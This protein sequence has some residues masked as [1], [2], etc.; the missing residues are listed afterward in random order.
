[1]IPIIAC[2]HP[3]ARQEV[4][5][6]KTATCTVAGYTGDTYCNDCGVK[7]YTGTTITAL[8]HSYSSKVTKHPTTI[9]EGIMTYTCS[10]CS[11]SY[12]RSIDKL[13]SDESGNAKKPYIKG[14]NGNEGW[15][16]IKNQTGKEED[17]DKITVEMNGTTI[18]PSD[19]VE[20]IRGKDVTLVLDMGDG[21]SWAIHGKDVTGTNLSDIDLKVS[22]GT[23]AIPVDV[24]N[25][26]TG[27]KYSMQ[28]SLAYEGE[29]GFK[30]TLSINM[31]KKNAGRY[32]SLFYYNEAMG[33]LEFMNTSL[34][35]AD[36]NVA[37]SFTH[38]S[39]YTI[40][41]EE[42]TVTGSSIDGSNTDT[43]KKQ[44]TKDNKNVSPATGNNNPIWNYIW[45]V[46]IGGMIMMIGLGTVIVK[47]KKEIEE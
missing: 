31:D 33:K 45:V 20:S 5:N 22:K 38:A 4:R 13:P 32:A 12:T 18:L 7:L 35:G 3:E 41:V 27:E 42:S 44:P 9:E 40:V 24:I 43:D 15:D 2:N 23:S 37:L 30:A 14:E 21:I 26:V 6:T 10:R 47:Q 28:I 16:V 8:G 29:F 11:D 1:M 39:D 46:V 36:G 34:I 17:G 25:E 19:I